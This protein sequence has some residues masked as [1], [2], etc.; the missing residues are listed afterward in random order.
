MVPGL[1]RLSRGSERKEPAEYL[2]SSM[3]S[4]IATKTVLRFRM[5]FGIG[6]PRYILRAIAPCQFL[7]TCP[8]HDRRAM[9]YRTLEHIAHQNI[10]RCITIYPCSPP[11]HSSSLTLYGW[12]IMYMKAGHFRLAMTCKILWSI[13][14][15][16][17]TWLHPPA[18]S[19]LEAT[20]MVTLNSRPSPG[21]HLQSIPYLQP[22]SPSHVPPS[23]GY[24]L[25]V[26]SRGLHHIMTLAPGRSPSS[27]CFHSAPLQT[28][29]PDYITHHR[30]TVALSP[31]LGRP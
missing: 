25:T 9:P 13:D 15:Q 7:R 29:A 28:L 27:Q 14:R 5:D 24:R 4:R 20:V 22:A 30:S 8:H 3:P 2:I 26:T 10:H 17:T 1:R 21:L 23:K 19:V 11:V 6:L 31:N 18:T 16:K 12:V